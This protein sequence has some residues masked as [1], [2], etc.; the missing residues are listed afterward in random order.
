MAFSKRSAACQWSAES[1]CT[2]AGKGVRSYFWTLTTPDETGAAEI[3]HRWDVFLK[4][5]RRYTLQIEF[6]R[7][8]EPHASGTRYHLHILLSAFIR[9]EL[10]REHA[11]EAGFGRL[12]VI[13]VRD[14]SLAGYMAK[15]VGKNKVR[16]SRGTRFWSCS[17]RKTGWVAHGVRDVEARENGVPIGKRLQDQCEIMGLTGRAADRF[18]RTTLMIGARDRHLHGLVAWMTWQ[19]KSAELR[20]DELAAWAWRD[21]LERRVRVP[22]RE[23][24]TQDSILRP[25]SAV[26]D[27]WWAVAA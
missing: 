5:L 12:H 1:F 22:G 13:R 2:R 17:R 6:I 4:R 9:V 11:K 18:R 16:K 27:G 7:V 10:V 14:S 19:I 24:M 25:V 21:S 8:L 15:Y 3:L 26:P 20:G 23:C